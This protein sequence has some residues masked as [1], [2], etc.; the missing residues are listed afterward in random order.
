VTNL[1]PYFQYNS[2]LRYGMLGDGAGQSTDPSSMQTWM[3]G[4]HIRCT[5]MTAGIAGHGV[6][7]SRGWN[8]PGGWGLIEADQYPNGWR[9]NDFTFGSRASLYRAMETDNPILRY[10]HH[11]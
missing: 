11:V 7:L 6:L 3:R 1:L 9:I 8:F 5:Y 4:A 2:G 10:P